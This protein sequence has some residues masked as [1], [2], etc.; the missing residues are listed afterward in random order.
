MG[1]WLRH[2]LGE[3]VTATAAPEGGRF[4]VHVREPSG[5]GRR[6]I[7][8]YRWGLK[9]AQAPAD[10]LVQEYYPHECDGQECG[11]WRRSE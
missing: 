11:A 7:D 5:A 10:R 6:P 1:I 2:H 4:F 3:T 9:D 8:F